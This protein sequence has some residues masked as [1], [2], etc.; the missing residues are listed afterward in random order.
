ME[1]TKTNYLVL[2][3]ISLCFILFIVGVFYLGRQSIKTTVTPATILPQVTLIPTNTTSSNI[4]WK[5]YKSDKLGV[6]FSYPSSWKVYESGPYQGQFVDLS[7]QKCQQA[8]PKCVENEEG[9]NCP[10]SLACEILGIR[11]MP[12]VK[13]VQE[14]FNQNKY[15]KD[16]K[17]VTFATF[18]AYQSIYTWLQTDG[19]GGPTI[20]VQ[21]GEKVYEISYG[22]EDLGSETQKIVSSIKFTEN[23]AEVPQ[24]ISDL[25]SEVNKLLPSNITPVA[26]DTFYSNSGPIDKQS[27]KLD[28]KN[29][30]INGKSLAT[31]LSSKLRLKD[32]LGGGIGGGGTDG[33]ENDQMV[34]VHTYFC[35]NYPQKCDNKIDFLSCTEK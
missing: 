23:K 4:D 9:G 5:V 14:L 2:A 35:D 15:Y 25:F 22:N 33:Y 30:N 3:L 8:D 18:P 24:P 13:T 31:L 17:Q 28:F 20:D 1:K 7:N 19:S 26:E 27:W 12:E 11:Y 32:D 29:I 6:S 10:A 21:V 34:C 16:I